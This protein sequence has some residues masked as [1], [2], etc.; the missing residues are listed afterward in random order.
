[1]LFYAKILK[2]FW[3]WKIFCDSLLCSRIISNIKSML[4]ISNFYLSSEIESIVL[5]CRESF[6][7]RHFPKDS[8]SN[9][10]CYFRTCLFGINLFWYWLRES[11]NQMENL[12]VMLW[13]F[14]TIQVSSFYLFNLSRYTY[15]ERG[16]EWITPFCNDN[17]FFMLFYLLLSISLT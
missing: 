1:M 7:L 10:F 15:Y 16:V 12:E 5:L 2:N 17:C 9:A 4:N 6:Q 11:L 13:T 14:P 8:C 3:A